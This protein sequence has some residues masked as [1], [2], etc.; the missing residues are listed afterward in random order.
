GRALLGGRPWLD[1][2][3]VLAL[4]PSH[5]QQTVLGRADHHALEPVLLGLMVLAAARLARGPGR[6]AVALLAAATALAFWNWNG[7]ALYLALLGGFAAAW[8][9]LAPPGDEAP[10]AAAARLAAG[11]LGGALLLAASLAL[12]GPASA[13]RSARISG[14][15]GRQPARA[16]GAAL[17]CAALAA[18]R[19]LRPAAAWPAR[20]ATAA[21]A[22]LLPAAVLAVW[23]WTRDGIGRG[24]TMLA[25]SGWYRTIMEFR[26]ILPSGLAPLDADLRSVL[27]S[28]GLTPLAV[29]AAL[30]LAWRRW[31]AGQG[32]DR[33]PALLLGVLVAGGLVLGWA[34]IRFGVYLALAAALSTALVSRELA[35]WVQARWPARRWAGPL[36]GAALAAALV[37][38]VLPSLPGADWAPRTPTRWTDLAPLSR[39]AGQL[40]TAPG[41]EA[42]LVPWSW[43]HDVRWFSGRPVVSSPFGIDGGAGA[44]EVDAAFHRLTDQAQ[45]EALLA[46]RRVGL[47]IAH[48]PL[49]E[50]VSLKDFAPAGAPEVF[51]PGPDPGRLDRVQ[52]LPAFRMLVAVRL[53]LW[54]GMW[55]EA[56][57]RPLAVGFPALDAFRL[58]GESP[59]VA[60]WQRVGVSAYKLF[61]P[62]PGARVEVR[63]ARP[64]ASVEARTTLR[65][66]R[67]REESWVTRA[68]AGPDGVA[69]FRL[70]YATGLNGAVAAA[71]WTFSDGTRQ[72]SLAPGERDVSLGLPLAA[73]LGR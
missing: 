31:R 66:N 28:H 2:A 7:S 56:D 52:V 22:L 14:L 73:T 69:R 53:W 4:L 33:G 49:D 30:P 40:R 44:L 29:V 54:D 21:A 20:A 19:R 9:V 68:A 48:E 65:T 8:H 43:G 18:A 37:A 51:R 41:R 13:I 26:P 58:V 72:A 62:V 63:G 46:S 45:V 5:A 12:L 50:V 38:P 1:A 16:G 25:A 70:P 57:G 15:T 47:V 6:G 10:G 39:L 64:G 35:A 27:Q 42:V 24:L 3:L 67:G 59:S 23:P 61:E 11:L 32:A 71:P 17:S 36:A 55:G 34:R 60:I